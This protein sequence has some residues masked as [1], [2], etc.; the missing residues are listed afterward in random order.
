MFDQT[1]K[2]SCNGHDVDCGCILGNSKIVYIKVG[3]E[4]SY[5]GYE[6]KKTITGTDIKDLRCA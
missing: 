4:G 6:N 1:C 2:V 5:L 3:M